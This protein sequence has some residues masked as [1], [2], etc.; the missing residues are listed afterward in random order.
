MVRRTSRT[1]NNPTNN[2][3]E[4]PVQRS[5][6]R[7][8]QSALT[9]FLQEIGVNAN[10]IR[11]NALRRQQELA[12]AEESLQE[13]RQQPSE[14]A[15]SAADTSTA[16]DVGPSNEQV[17]F[18]AAEPNGQSSAAVEG[19]AELLPGTSSGSASKKRK[20]PSK[21]SKKDSGSDSDDGDDDYDN[22]GLGNGLNRSSARKGGKIYN[23][24]MCGTR[25]L[26]RQKIISRSERILCTPCTRS[27]EKAK[28]QSS[29]PP[30]RRNGGAR[31]PAARTRRKL[32]KTEDGL[33]ELDTGLPSLQDLCIRK[34]GRHIHDISS[35]GDISE[36]SL[37]KVCKIICKLR[38]LT[39]DTVKLFLSRERTRVRLYDCTKLNTLGLRQI[40]DLSSPDM[41]TE[42]RLNFCGQ[43]RDIDLLYLG[44]MLPNLRR[45]ELHGPFLVTDDSGFGEFFR[46]IGGRLKEFSISA[47]RFGVGAMRALVENCGEGLEKLRLA[48]CPNIGDDCLT[49]ITGLDSESTPRKRGSSRKG[50]EAVGHNDSGEPVLPLL[51]NLRSLEIDG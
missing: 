10:E 26:V 21:K 15:D 13:Q 34:I 12:L 32:K 43:M 19:A 42:L 8:P 48:E 27:V 37:D 3:G 29:G 28:V 40:V 23:C 41:V 4:R 5:R 11:I 35:F 16:D 31:Q 50:K 51:T 18:S 9:S 44:R 17:E 14:T 24:D 20:K 2:G 47:A 30:A 49:L 22:E 38:E 46:L 36:E 6:V 7:G 1:A 33:L 25:F 39:N 45:V